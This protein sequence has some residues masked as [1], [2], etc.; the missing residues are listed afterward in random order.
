MHVFSARYYK[1]IR[2][3]N[4]VYWIESMYVLFTYKDVQSVQMI[5]MN[6]DNHE[7]VGQLH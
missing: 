3:G 2:T 6:A 7:R 5:Q 4:I 1:T